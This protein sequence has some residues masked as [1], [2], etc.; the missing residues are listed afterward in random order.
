MLLAV[1]GAAGAALP[2]KGAELQAHDHIT[3]GHNWHVEFLVSKKNPRMVETLVVYAEVCGATL[4]RVHV[5]ISADGVVSAWGSGQGVGRMQLYAKFVA[6]D[7]N[8]GAMRLTRGTCDSGPIPFRALTDAAT[9]QVHGRTYPTFGGATVHQL[10]Q[11]QALRRRAWQASRK[12]FPT[13]K[14][15]LARGYK[16]SSNLVP[17]PVIFHVRNRRYEHDGLL[18]NS[19]RPEALVYWWRPKGKSIL[20]G[21]M[22][23]VPLGDRPSF[24]GPIPIYHQH[25]GKRVSKPMTHVWLTNDLVSAWANC[26]PIAALEA[27]HPEFHYSAPPR[28]VPGPSAP[29]P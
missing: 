7:A 21:F 2:V 4:L 26:S 3:E 14:A 29:C 24:G 27:A 18:F 15:A 20:L 5:P 1:P 13:Y 28:V 23:R 10:R 11:V 12:V 9:Q 16:R 19:R 25:F 22:F 17:R 8:E 6:P